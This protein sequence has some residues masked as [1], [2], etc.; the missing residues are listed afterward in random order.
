MPGTGSMFFKSI[1]QEKDFAIGPGLVYH[2]SRDNHLFV[3]A[4]FECAAENR[5]EG[6]RINLR[7]V[8]HF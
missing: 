6:S 8:H 3:N 4:Y 5:P 1:A 2:F 7:V